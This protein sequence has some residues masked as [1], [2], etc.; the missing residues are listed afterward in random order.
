MQYTPLKLLIIFKGNFCRRNCEWEIRQVLR[1]AEKRTE[2]LTPHPPNSR[3]GEEIESEMKREWGTPIDLRHI[4][5]IFGRLPTSPIDRLP[6]PT[7]P[8]RSRPA[9]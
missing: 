5:G 6:T 4:R 3:L 2:V 8:P 9:W 7:C 1:Y